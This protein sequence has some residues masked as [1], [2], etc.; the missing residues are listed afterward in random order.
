MA[1]PPVA[2]GANHDTTTLASP[3]AVVTPVGE[4]GTV[5]GVTGED[6]AELTLLPTRFDALTVNVYEV[7][8]VNPL[9]DAEVVEAITVAPPGEAVTE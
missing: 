8:F 3:N 7:P 9:N 6:G 1:A 5:A 2:A 4:P